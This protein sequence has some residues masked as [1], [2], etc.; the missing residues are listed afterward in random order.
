MGASGATT[1][2]ARRDLKL[3]VT[4]HSFTHEYTSYIWSFE[5][6]MEHAAK[7]GG[8]VEIVGPTHH[9]GFPHV[10]DEFE[11]AFTSSVARLGL[12]PTAYGSYA[13]PFLRWDRQLS[14]EELVAYTLPQIRGAAR[15]GF[16]IV[17]MQHFAADIIERVLPVAEELN[18]ILAYELHT[19]LDITS[20]RTLYLVDQLARIDSPHLGLIPDAGLFARSLS[21]DQRNRA[22][23]LGVTQEAV[24]EIAAM[25]ARQAPLEDAQ[26]L[27]TERGAPEPSAFWLHMLWGAYG[28]SDPADLATISR[29]I[30]HVHGKFY[31]MEDHQEPDLRYRELVFALLDIGYAGWISSEYEGAP[32]DSFRLVWEHQRMIRRY[33]EEY[34]ALLPKRR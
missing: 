3:G 15:L 26:A 16:P 21:S 20:K 1:T 18:V 28:H 23:E 30:V 2:V 31:S 24:D 9:R 10:P 7:L 29:W 4:L 11:T 22:V 17:R 25:W 19:P 27:L 5:D 32:S 12:T 14:D 13:D 34:H 8:G 6:L 33:V